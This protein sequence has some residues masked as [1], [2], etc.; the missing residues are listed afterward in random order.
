MKTNIKIIKA[1]IEDKKPQTIRELSKR[2]KADYKIT[3]L[4]VQQ[5][6][7][8]KIILFKKV[9]KST[10]CN[11]N[12]SFYGPE[13]HQAEEERKENILRNKDLRQLYKEITDKVKTSFFI[14]LLFGSYAKGNQT[15][16]SDIDLMFIS[17]EKGFDDKIHTF[18][19]LLPL[20]THSLTFTEKEFR[21][22]AESKKLSVVKEALENN[23]I[24]YGIEN[25]YKLKSD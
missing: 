2:I 9:G 18:L 13:I 3:Y 19:S 5:L 25:F 6:I 4:G 21:E 24:L 16:S 23:I 11:L 22:M 15:K 12:P 7:A 8:K 17:N 10:S 1:L 14:L 20:K